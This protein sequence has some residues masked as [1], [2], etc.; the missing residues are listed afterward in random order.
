MTNKPEL[1]YNIQV[2]RPYSDKEIMGYSR[3]IADA[4]GVKLV[5]AA[6]LKAFSD[7]IKDEIAGQESIVQDCAARIRQG[8]ENVTKE[9][10]VKY[11]GNMVS[12]IDKNSGEVI[13]KHEITEEEQ[14]RLTSKSIDAEQIIRQDNEE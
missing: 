10:L 4:I 3:N 7:K 6:E 14:L 13:E 2:K 11:D 1:T 8:Y 5:K 12:Y 9:C